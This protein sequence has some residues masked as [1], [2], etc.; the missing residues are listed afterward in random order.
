M[1]QFINS[2]LCHC[3]ILKA[4]GLLNSLLLSLGIIHQPL[5]ILYTSTAVIIGLVYSLLPFMIL[6]LYANI[7]KLDTQFIDAARD[8][9]ANSLTIF[10]A[11]FYR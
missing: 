1:D 9:G 8:L 7:E 4:K 10:N 2:Y 3:L 6:P 5:T 11:L